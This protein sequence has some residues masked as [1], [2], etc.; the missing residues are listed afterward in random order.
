MP[1]AVE[2]LLIGGGF[3]SAHCAAELRKRGDDDLA[4]EIE[5]AGKLPGT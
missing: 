1:E 3:A 2:Y 4:E 5:K